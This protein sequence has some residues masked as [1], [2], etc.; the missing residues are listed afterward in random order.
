MCALNVDFVLDNA[1]VFAV[2]FYALEL[3]YIEAVSVDTLKTNCTN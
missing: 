2:F 3:L 1:F